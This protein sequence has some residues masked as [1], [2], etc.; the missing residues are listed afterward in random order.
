MQTD[1][2]KV[3]SNGTGFDEALEETTKFAT[4]VG[5]DEK[6]A[7]RLRLLAEE[8]LGMVSAIT[9]DFK[10]DFWLENKKGDLYRIYLKAKTSMDLDKKR[11]LIDASTNKK[12]AAS[13]GFMGKIRELV[14]N[15]VYNANEVEDL[16]AEYGGGNVLYASM[17]MYDIN[18][19]S[20][21]NAYV[22]QWSLERYRASIEESMR[23]NQAVQ[24]AGDELEKSIVANIADDVRVGV[25]GNEVEMVIEKKLG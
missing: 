17:G 1:I 7:L 18:A 12:N 16:K 22:Y 3:K 25:R 21:I 19:S 11:E 6:Q 2:I 24:E 13:K 8:T 20:N 10:A 4:Y 15:G 9:G 5:L 23:E 14:E